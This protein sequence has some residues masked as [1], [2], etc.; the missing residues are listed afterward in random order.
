MSSS[1]SDGECGELLF[2]GS[3]SHSL[4]G[5]N[6]GSSKD[7]VEERNIT[8]FSKIMPGI[9]IRKVFSGCI[10]C[11]SIAVAEDGTSYM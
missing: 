9:K 2:A 6:G 3:A 7:G 4:T 1:S 8:T 11:H 5:R 10:A